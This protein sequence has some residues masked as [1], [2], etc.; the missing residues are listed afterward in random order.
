MVACYQLWGTVFVFKS[1]VHVAKRAGEGAEIFVVDEC[2][3]VESQY[4]AHELFLKRWVT[5]CLTSCQNYDYEAAWNASSLVANPRPAFDLD[6]DV[7]APSGDS[8]T[9][10]SHLPK[11]LGA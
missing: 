9:D 3:I 2:G 1:D 7:M 8:G 5:Q 6:Q 10:L 4:K 11:T